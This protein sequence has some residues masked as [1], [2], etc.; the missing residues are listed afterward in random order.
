MIFDTKDDK[1]EYITIKVNN[2]D[3]ICEKN[4]YTEYYPSGTIKQIKVCK[5]E[6]QQINNHI[7]TITQQPQPISF[8]INGEKQILELTGNINLYENGYVKCCNFT[9]KTDR[10][11]VNIAEM[12]Q[13]IKIKEDPYTKESYCYF[14]SNGN[15]LST[16]LQ[17]EPQQL[18]LEIG[19]I[20]Q[21]LDVKWEINLYDNGK[22]KECY[23]DKPTNIECH[24]NGQRLVIKLDNA[25][26]KKNGFWE[27]VCDYI[28]FFSDGTLKEATI[29]ED[30]IL[31]VKFHGKD[32]DLPFK[33]GDAIIFN[34]NKELSQSCIDKSSERSSI[35]YDERLSKLEKSQEKTKQEVRKLQEDQN[36]ATKEDWKFIKRCTFIGFYF[37]LN[38]FCLCFNKVG[39][40][41]FPL[42]FILPENF[43][44]M[45][46]DYRIP[47]FNT[48]HE[49]FNKYTF[50]YEILKRAPIIIL[51][52]LGFKFL[53]L[54][55]E[56]I[57]LVGEVEK[58]QKYLKLAQ[59]DNVKNNLLGI[60]AVPFFTHKKQKQPLLDR[61]VD[62]IHIDIDKEKCNNESSDVK[63]IA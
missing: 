60:I 13:S 38:A 14:Y 57:R 47:F 20:K 52:I 4:K 45:C 56:R 10:I 35:V 53:Q 28:S 46:F 61:L 44:K 39:W 30:T 23:I 50:F 7:T 49:N 31:N 55:F 9:T 17:D 32:Y 18:K 3:L 41:Q 34:D 21:T 26:A 63:K 51:I 2:Q 37:I 27:K 62:K 33:N 5:K 58:V 48:E 11:I 1:K 59:G 42:N 22:L 12:K 40:W 6:V 19:D 43:D 29:C 25:I 36:L 54:A 24:I 15:L 16:R 8:T